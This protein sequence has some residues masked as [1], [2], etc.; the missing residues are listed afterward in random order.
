MSG[1]DVKAGVG[2]L[3]PTQEFS[4]PKLECN[5]TSKRS[6]MISMYLDSNL[7]EVTLPHS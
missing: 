7:K 5:I 2:N 3:R 4:L 6:R 1:Y